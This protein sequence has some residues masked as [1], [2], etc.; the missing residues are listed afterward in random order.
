VGGDSFWSQ[1]L[2]LGSLFVVTSS[3]F[4]FLWL[5]RYLGC[6]EEAGLIELSLFLLICLLF[7]LPHIM[8]FVILF[9]VLVSDGPVNFASRLGVG[10]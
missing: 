1:P 6:L 5:S 4:A 3:C 8:S 2:L 10:V 9:C 7:A